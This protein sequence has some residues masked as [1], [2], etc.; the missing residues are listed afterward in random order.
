MSQEHEQLVEKAIEGIKEV[1]SDK[2]VPQDT[3]RASLEILIQEIQ[4]LIRTLG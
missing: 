4:D 1:F 3:T 2:S